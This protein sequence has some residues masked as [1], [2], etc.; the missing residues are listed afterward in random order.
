M[1]RTLAGAR[2]NFGDFEPEPV[3][4]DGSLPHAVERMFGLICE[5]AGMRVVESS[6]L[7][8]IAKPPADLSRIHVIALYLPQFHP[9]PE[10]DKWWGAGFTEWTNDGGL[11]HPTFMGL[12]E[13]VSP[14]QCVREVA[15]PLSE[16]ESAD[17]A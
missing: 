13:D 14:E 6:R 17:G 16:A 7:T 11:R 12:R 3:K 5:D 15:T 8:E 2:I 1:L 4:E 9:V 10:N